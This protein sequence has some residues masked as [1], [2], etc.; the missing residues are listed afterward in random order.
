MYKIYEKAL[1][2][3]DWKGFCVK[4]STLH[5]VKMNAW[6]CCSRKGEI[7]LTSGIMQ[8]IQTNK[9]GHNSHTT[10]MA[11]DIIFPPHQRTGP[12]SAL[13]LANIQRFQHVPFCSGI[14]KLYLLRLRENATKSQLRVHNL[15]F[16]F[17]LSALD[18][19]TWMSWM[20]IDP[21]TLYTR[22]CFCRDL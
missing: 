9:N 6:Y 7:D 4:R 12:S 5:A 14:W 13:R 18:T 10:L 15:T 1:F 17:I 21:W 8:K 3:R 2:L 19:E 11:T 22:V 20:A 16:P